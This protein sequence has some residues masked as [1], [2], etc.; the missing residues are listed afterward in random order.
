MDLYLYAKQQITTIC[1]YVQNLAQ[2][3]LVF[4]AAS[5]FLFALRALATAFRVERQEMF[6]SSLDLEHEA[7]IVVVD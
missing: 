1:I 4:R 6:R 7:R 5:F 2:V 3:C